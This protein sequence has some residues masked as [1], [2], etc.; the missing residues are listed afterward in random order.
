[1]GLRVL[2]GGRAPERQTE[3]SVGY[4]AFARES[5]TIYPGEWT[6]VP[7]GVTYEGV[8]DRLLACDVRPRSG[9]AFRHGVTVLNSPG[10][11]DP[12]YREEF[13]VLLINHGRLPFKVEAGDR[14]CQLVFPRW[15]SRLLVPGCVSKDEDRSGGFGSTGR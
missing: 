3:F 6:R 14:V 2:D 12:D 11:I 10:T 4:D 9:L 15:D 1:M 5:V 8:T 7:L 13:A